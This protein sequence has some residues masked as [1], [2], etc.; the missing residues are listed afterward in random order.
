VGILWTVARR[1]PALV[2]AST[3]PIYALGYDWRQSNAESARDIAARADE[4]LRQHQAKKLILVTHSMGGLVA[5]AAMSFVPGFEAKVL[6][7]IHTVQPVLGAA[8]N[9]SNF[10][11]G[12][13]EPGFQGFF[14][15]QILGPAAWQFL[16]NMVHLPGPVQLLPNAEYSLPATGAV[17]QPPSGLREKLPL[18]DWLQAYGDDGRW[19]FSSN[20][21]D[22]YE[23]YGIPGVTQ[24]WQP[25]MLPHFIPSVWNA[26]MERMHDN[27]ETARVFHQDLKRYMHPLTKVV[28]SQAARNTL[29]GVI[30]FTHTTLGISSTTSYG[31]F[32]GSGDGTVPLES[33]SALP[34]TPGWPDATA[35]HDGGHAEIFKIASAR[36]YVKQCITAMLAQRAAGL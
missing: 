1:A 2:S 13:N 15:D 33:Q 22:A 6:G 35:R 27:L 29:L 17:A 32:I 30:S 10:V 23:G 7:V 36:E 11:R 3:N 8:K 34:G 4:V 20:I 25:K 5:R 26:M 24:H 14:L 9:Y 16:A 21:F 18:T 12:P 31:Q 28:V 19:G